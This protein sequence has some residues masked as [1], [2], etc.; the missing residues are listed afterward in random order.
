MAS[1]TASEKAAPNITFFSSTV[2]QTFCVSIEMFRIVL[3]HLDYLLL[4]I[5][6]STETYSEVCHIAKVL[7]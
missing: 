4:N 3:R 6:C 5:E 1:F 7:F 2:A